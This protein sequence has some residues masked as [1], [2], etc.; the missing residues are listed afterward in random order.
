MAKYINRH[1]IC[2]LDGVSPDKLIFTKEPI[3]MNGDKPYV[4]R[5]QAFISKQTLTN[6]ILGCNFDTVIRI[7]P[8][9]IV[10]MTTKKMPDAYCVIYYVKLKEPV[11]GSVAQLVNAGDS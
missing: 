1:D 2:S 3:I 6:F 8:K 10:D 11:H 9:D 4:L 5:P 7:A